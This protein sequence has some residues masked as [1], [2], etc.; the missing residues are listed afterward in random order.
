MK[1]LTRKNNKAAAAGALLLAIMLTATACGAGADQ[2]SGNEQQGSASPTNEAGNQLP[3]ETGVID[4]EAPTNDETNNSAAEPNEESDNDGAEQTESQPIGAEG[5]YTGQIDS[6]SI[7]IVTDGV[8]AAY[9]IPEDLT[10][11]IETLPADAEV[12]FEYTEK[13]IE[14]EEAVKQLWLTKIEAVK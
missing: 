7:E 9:Q 1:K 8:A 13:A 3:E 2:P 5:V 10:A 4:P 12:K 6:H 14:G 11:V